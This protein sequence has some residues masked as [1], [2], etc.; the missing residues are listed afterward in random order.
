M[1]GAL[2]TMVPL[3]GTLRMGQGRPPTKTWFLVK[4]SSPTTAPAPPP[5][6]L[7]GSAPFRDPML[8]ATLVIVAKDVNMAT[9]KGRGMCK[10]QIAGPTQLCACHTAT[11]HTQWQARTLKGSTDISLLFFTRTR[12]YKPGGSAGT[13]KVAVV[14][15]TNVLAVEATRTPPWL[16]RML[17]TPVRPTPV[18][19]SVV[20][21][22]PLDGETVRMLG[23]EAREYLC[24]GREGATLGSGGV[25]LG[26][27][28]TKLRLLGIPLG[29]ICVNQ[30]AKTITHSLSLW[31]TE[32]DRRSG[33]RH[34]K[35]TQT[36]SRQGR[37]R[38][39]WQRWASSHS[40]P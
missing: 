38:L 18:T 34:Q 30:R 8:E 37:C 27:N 14:E 15:L 26:L 7:R 10:A 19:V 17:V 23:V 2:Q 16:N 22:A 31:H 9:C 1:V 20:P 29:T 35:L 6:M 40:T 36:C 33:Y 39:P 21:A 25:G 4:P 24:I 13:V 3:S 12:V 32:L 11:K 28:P 5:E